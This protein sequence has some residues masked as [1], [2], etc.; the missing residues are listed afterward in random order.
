MNLTSK[1]VLQFMTVCAGACALS[2]SAAND[3]PVADS[4]EVSDGGANGM[5]IGEYKKFLVNEVD[6]QSVWSNDVGDASVITN[7]TGGAYGGATR[8]MSAGS[9]DLV[10]NLAT[11]GQTLSRVLDSAKDFTVAPVYV[12]TLI[13]FTPSED[14]PTISDESVK[15]AVYVN[16]ASN[17]VIYHNNL[18]L[19]AKV[20]TETSF[21]VNPDQ[22][23]RLTIQLTSITGQKLFKV[24]IDG[25]AITSA[26]AYDETGAHPGEWFATAA[27]DQT[28]STVAFQGTGMVDELVVTETE[29]A[30]L[31]VPASIL[32]T[33]AYNPAQAGVSVLGGGSIANG[34]TVATG[35]QII[36]DA[37][38]WY[39]VTGTSGTGDGAYAGPVGAVVNV[40]TGAV[41]ATAAST[42][43][44]TTAQYTGSMPVGEATIDLAKMSA[45]ALANTKTEAQVWA[46]GADWY[47]EYLL[48]IAPDAGTVQALEITSIKIIGTD[49]EIKVS[50]M[51]SGVHFAPGA[52]SINGVLKVITMP[53][54]GGTPTTT[55][56]PFTG[57]TEATILVPLADG[58]FMKAIVE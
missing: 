41:S 32:L 16:V 40:T 37:A 51:A 46:A 52:G 11:E 45:W 42:L 6:Y 36:I 25:T 23:Y 27:N 31:G 53:T 58:K 19:A 18:D 47:D 3:W 13:K 54:L 15:A 56:Y 49:A 14:A 10:L 28:I 24:Y 12:D 26:L 50:A 33:L 8:P 38:D 5:A 20:N 17:L 39:S 21:H 29:P 22:W 35:T 57:D 2:A 34:G 55:A 43:T 44:I 7:A 48:N 4:F 1:R 30:G 9:T